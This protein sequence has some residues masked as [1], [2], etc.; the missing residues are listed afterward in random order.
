MRAYMGT[1]DIRGAS[2][3]TRAD[4]LRNALGALG[5]MAPVLYHFILDGAMAETLLL[6]GLV[7]LGS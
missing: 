4:F 7:A 5:F 6:A 2:R 1:N 3:L